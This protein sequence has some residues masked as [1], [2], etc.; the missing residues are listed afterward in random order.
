MFKFEGSGICSLAKGKEPPSLALLTA[1]S[2]RR[3][4]R[5]GPRIQKKGLDSK[6]DKETGELWAGLH[7][8][9]VPGS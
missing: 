3:Q 4:E 9:P 6:K 7:L 2:Q 8:P 1:R 5:R